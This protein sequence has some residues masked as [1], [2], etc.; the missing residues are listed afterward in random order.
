M[1]IHATTDVPSSVLFP[2][3]HGIGD[4]P[5]GLEGGALEEFFGYPSCSPPPYRGLTIMRVP[6]PL[7]RSAGG[8]E[9]G[10]VASGKQA[11]IRPGPGT[12]D[13]AAASPAS[14]VMERDDT[15]R[16][17][18]APAQQSR[19]STPVPCTIACPKPASW[20]AM[21]RWSA[22]PAAHVG[23]APGG[24]LSGQERLSARTRSASYSTTV[25]TSASS[26]M[27]SEPSFLSLSVS[28]P[29]DSGFPHAIWGRGPAASVDSC[30]GYSPSSS[31]SSSVM[32]RADD[33]Q[34][35]EGQGKVRTGNSSGSSLDDHSCMHPTASKSKLASGPTSTQGLLERLETSEAAL[36]ARGALHCA[37]TGHSGAENVQVPA[38]PSSAS[39]SI[40]SYHA[41]LL[42]AAPMQRSRSTGPLSRHMA[43]TP[44]VSMSPDPS[45]PKSG[46]RS[47]STSGRSRNHSPVPSRPGTPRFK[48]PGGASTA[49]ANEKATAPAGSGSAPP[50]TEGQ[51]A[52]STERTV[53]ALGAQPNCRLVNSSSLDDL[54]DVLDPGTHD[55]SFEFKR[56]KLSP[57]VSLRNLNVQEVKYT[58]I[59]DIVLYGPAMSIDPSVKQ[60]QL[61]ALAQRCVDP[62]A[63]SLTSADRQVL[64]GWLTPKTDWQGSVCRWSSSRSSSSWVTTA[65]K[66]RPTLRELYITGSMWCKA[67]ELLATPDIPAE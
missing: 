33:D 56:P 20:D 23:A 31:V 34:D 5:K 27:S 26:E 46:L 17:R 63:D 12:G 66:Y 21:K 2:W 55:M 1:H 49:P 16:A 19:S 11:Q 28:H 22:A 43:P 60:R 13:A 67:S 47:V 35:K 39:P 53:S 36:H 48:A 25:S 10:A 64:A 62:L 24:E 14:L 37:L 40:S 30:S 45:D 52:G 54:L 18:E 32:W 6:T 4:G 41:S 7:L 42:D 59:S 57:E 51:A 15:V 58:T 65:R 61:L 9:S 38:R 8:L 3:L 29:R 44:R 50:S